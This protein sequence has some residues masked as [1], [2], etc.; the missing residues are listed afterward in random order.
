MVVCYTLVAE[1][2]PGTW[3]GIAIL[4]VRLQLGL[5]RIIHNSVAY[6]TTYFTHPPYSHSRVESGHPGGNCYLK[7]PASTQPCAYYTQ[8]SSIE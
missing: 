3:M 7:P 5:V 4:S 8:S 2:N 6:S 1:L